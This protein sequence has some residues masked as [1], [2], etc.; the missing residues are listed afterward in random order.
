MKILWINSEASFTGGAET[1]INQTARVLNEAYNTQ[2]ILLYSHNSRVDIEFIKVFSFATVVAD[3]VLQINSIKPDVIYVHQ[4]HDNSILEKLTTVNIPIVAFIHDHKNFCLREHKYRTLSKE[5]CT[6][7]IGMNCYGCLG[8]INKH[9]SFPYLS[10]N[11]VSNVKK[12]QEYYKAFDCCIVASEYMKKHLV[13]HDFNEKKIEKI[14]LFTQNTQLETEDV[15]KTGIKRFLFVGQLINGKGVDTLLKAFAILCNNNRND[16][17]HLDICGD[18]KQQQM[19]KILAQDLN[20]TSSVTFYGNVAQDKLDTIYRSSYTVVVPSR[21]PETFNL[22]G[23]EAMKNSKAVIAS[24]VGG[25]REWLKEGLTGIGTK[26]NDTKDLAKALQYAIN[27]PS[28]IQSFGQNAYIEYLKNFNPA[29][30][31]KALN[32]LFLNINK[33]LSYE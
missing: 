33:E 11:T 2:N 16:D 1:Y 32:N 14:V 25:I 7:A 9:N 6:K 21:A 15:A 26:S 22:V 27:N 4:I 28:K 23:L 24:D 31:Y 20:I 3:L 18:G 5:T 17:I 13:L 8:F 30:H 29:A 10:I 19:L 12:V